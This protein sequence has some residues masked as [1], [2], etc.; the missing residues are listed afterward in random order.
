MSWAGP[1][2]MPMKKT[3]CIL[4]D[5]GNTPRCSVWLDELS[6]EETTGSTAPS[7]SRA[8]SKE[9]KRRDAEKAER[10][11][12]GEVLACMLVDTPTHVG[13]LLGQRPGN[14]S[15]LGGGRRAS[16]PRSRVRAFRRFLNRLAVNSQKGYP[17]E[18]VRH[19]D[20]MR[21]RMTEPC[22]RS[23]LKGAHRA[24]NLFE[25]VLGTQ[26][27]ER[28]TSTAMYDVIKEELQVAS[29]PARTSKQAPRMHSLEMLVGVGR[30]GNYVRCGA[31]YTLRVPHD[32]GGQG[33]AIPSFAT[34]RAMS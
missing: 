4:F 17:T 22:N 27:T 29:A 5:G 12:K 7:T 9:K 16:T 33:E 32:S 26:K 20:H 28:L 23:A 13:K 18:F 25:E 10:Q 2:P 31:L 14:K 15:L 11:R 30:I 24:F 1:P 34:V 8:S 21:A 6:K 19:T 3:G